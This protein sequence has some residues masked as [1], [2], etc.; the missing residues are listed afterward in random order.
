MLSHCSSSFGS[1]SIPVGVIGVSSPCWVLNLI[2]VCLCDVVGSKLLMFCLFW[3]LQ[4]LLNVY[5]VSFFE[6]PARKL[7]SF[8][9]CFFRSANLL[10]CSAGVQ[11]CWQIGQCA[12]ILLSSSFSFSSSLIIS[13]PS[14]LIGA[15]WILLI[16]SLASFLVSSSICSYRSLCLLNCTNV[17]LEALSYPSLYNV[18]LFSSRHLILAWR[19]SLSILKFSLSCLT[20]SN[21][22]S[23]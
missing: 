2:V 23:T 6:R 22:P 3:K 5:C 13:W 10:L 11:M 15:S 20:Y 8:R 9:G 21:A 12:S 18:L 16:D 4:Y 17:S 1:S 14:G 7:C 19:S